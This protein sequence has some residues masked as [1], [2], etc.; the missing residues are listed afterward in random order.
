LVFAVIVAILLLISSSL[1]ADDARKWG[2]VRHST[3]DKLRAGV[4][5]G[6]ISMFVFIGDAVVHFMKMQGKM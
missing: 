1:L 5:F 6:F 4:A 2:S 3:I